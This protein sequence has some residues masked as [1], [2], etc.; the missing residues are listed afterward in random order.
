[1]IG[2]GLLIGTL[3]ITA[4]FVAPDKIPSQRAVTWKNRI[5][6]FIYPENAS[7]DASRQVEY[8]KM[9]V[10]EGGLI[11]KG[12]GKSV[13]KNLLSQS[14]SDFIFAIIIEE[15]GLV[16]G[17][18]LLFFYLLLLFRIVVVANSVDTVF[19]KLLVIGVGLPIVFQAFINMA[20][21]VELFPTTGQPLPL[22]SMGGTSI[23]M[24]CLAIGIVLS[25]SNKGEAEKKSA[26]IDTANPLDLLSRQL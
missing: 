1:M 13:M 10:A 22:I 6:T 11:G 14:T 9:A 4:L 26:N 19:S 21:V 25:A 23:W 18:G 8:A 20:V 17:L 16:G 3:F 12:A 15:Y 24:T 5:E 7:A 2:V